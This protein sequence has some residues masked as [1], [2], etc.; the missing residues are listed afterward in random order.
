MK[1][2][3]SIPLAIALVLGGCS[4]AVTPTSL[5]TT[6]TAIEQDIIGFTQT[7][8]GFQPTIA[9]VEGIITTLFP[10][11]AIA[12]VPEQVVAQTICSV[13]PPVP[14]TASG[15]LGAAAAI[16]YPG[17]HIVIHGSYVGRVGSHYRGRA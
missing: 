7:L 4:T 11:A 17:T 3:S 10:G 15:R 8:C 13:I 5:T 9:T 1:F 16:V 14:V 12:T 6:L 2:L